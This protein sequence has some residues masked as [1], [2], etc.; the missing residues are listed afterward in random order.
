MKK[1]LLSIAGFDPSGG[2]GVLADLRVFRDLGFAGAAALTALTVQ[3]T[4]AVEKVEPVR[5]GL[6]A[7]QVE[8]LD[9]DMSLAGIKVGMAANAANLRVIGRFCASHPGIPRVVDPVFEASAG[10][11]LLDREGRAA[12]ISAWRGRATVLT[13]N[14]DEAGALTGA[15]ITTVEGMI[16]AARALAR[17]LR[18]PCLVKGGHLGGEAVNVLHDG[19]RAC[20]FGR[21]RLRRDVHGTGCLFSAALLAYLAKGKNLPRA[22]A[23]ATDFTHAAIAGS[24]RI[25]RGRRV[26]L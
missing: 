13:P 14:L 12:F 3:T 10:R 4:A 2:A 23:L 7:A 16:A 15:E 11:P 17:I 26:Y 24:A 22:A 1:T 20:L 18:F 5:P 21:P 19:S 8:A 6:L 25:G 9:A